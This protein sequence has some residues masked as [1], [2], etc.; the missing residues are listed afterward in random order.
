[1][2][3]LDWRD[4]APEHVLPLLQ[5]ERRRYVERLHWD[6]GPALRLVEAARVRGEVPGLVIRDGTG[7]IAGWAFYVLISITAIAAIPLYLLTSGGQA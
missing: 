1:M 2:T 3:L 5:A 4:L 7:A 6:L